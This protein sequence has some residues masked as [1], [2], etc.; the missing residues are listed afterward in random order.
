MSRT[1]RGSQGL[2]I[3]VSKSAMNN[4]SS[5]GFSFRNLSKCRICN[6]PA[7][8]GWILLQRLKCLPSIKEFIEP[9]ANTSE[10]IN[11]SEIPE[12]SIYFPA[13]LKNA[14]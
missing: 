9:S 5:T 3:A 12:P 13:V 6:A 2:F 1:A 8:Y 11:I 4:S 7:R 10:A 14:S